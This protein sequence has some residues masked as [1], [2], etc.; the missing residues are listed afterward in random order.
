MCTGLVWERGWLRRYSDW[1]TVGMIEELCFNFQQQQKK[2]LVSETQ[3]PAVP[4]QH[5]MLWLLGIKGL[6]PHTIHIHLVP[7]L[8]LHA[9]LPS[10][11]KMRLSCCA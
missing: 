3:R 2:I 9:A 6:E 4:T 5:S 11:P 10:F 1:A 8:T 7:E